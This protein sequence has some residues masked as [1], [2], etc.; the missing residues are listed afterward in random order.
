MYHNSVTNSRGT[1]VLISRKLKHDVVDIYNDN[2]GNAL[3]IKITTGNTTVTIGSI[4]G[5][6]NDDLDFY[7]RLDTAIKTHNSDFTIIGGD[8]NTTLDPRHNN[9]NIDTFNTMGI[10]STRRSIRLGQLCDSNNLVDPF[11]HFYPDKREYTYVPFPAAAVNRSRLDFFLIS[12]SLLEYCINCRIP[13]SLSSTNFDHKP[14]YLIF[15]RDNPYKKQRINYI[16]L[17]DDDLQGVVAICVI[18]TYINHL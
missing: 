17:K 7:D 12:E 10:P 1:A 8:W 11:R 2:D 14:V 3:L 5:P 16:I 6:N 9:I 18:E 13:N 4:Y 15:R